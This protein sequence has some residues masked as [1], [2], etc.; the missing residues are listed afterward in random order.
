[1]KTAALILLTTAWLASWTGIALG[2][3]GSLTPAQAASPQAVAV[4][5]R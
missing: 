5:G 2:L 4:A 3:S 1:M